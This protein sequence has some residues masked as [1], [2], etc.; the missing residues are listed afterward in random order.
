M[1]H[2]TDVSSTHRI[3]LL[4]ISNIILGVCVVL[5]LC[6]MWLVLKQKD[7]LN[8]ENLAIKLELQK[9]ANGS[10]GEARAQKGDLFPSLD[11]FN[12]EGK[13]T[14]IA[15]DGS[16][17]Y[18]LFFFSPECGTCLNQFPLWNE[19]AMRA[20]ARGDRVIGIS[21]GSK[22]DTATKL[23]SE[24]FELVG[25]QDMAVFRA[26]R[27]AMMPMVVVASPQGRAEWLHYGPL[28]ND[29]VKELVSYLET[30]QIRK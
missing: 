9:S 18:L 15:Y 4:R 28:T 24:S 7:K 30:S 13:R 26:Y 22:K 12:S 3:T 17:R 14:A 6:F 11:A 19:I 2:S 1:S 20:K 23:P 29:D 10:I 5:A 8:R 27:V 21:S 16:S 25:I